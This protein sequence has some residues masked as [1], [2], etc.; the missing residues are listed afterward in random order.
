MTSLLQARAAE[1]QSAISLGSFRALSPVL[2]TLSVLS[3][4]ALAG[5]RIGEGP[6]A[7]VFA[8]Q[9]LLLAAFIALSLVDFRAAVAIAVIELVVGGTGGRWTEFPGDISGR[10]ALD[11]IVTARAAALLVERRRAAFL[12]RRSYS[13]HAVALAFVIPLV[14]MTLGLVN[15]WP[16]GDVFADGNG[17]I[18]FAFILVIAAL[19]QRGD[20][21][22]FRQWVFVACALNAALIGGL[23]LASASGWIS[24]RPTLDETLIGDLDM[25]GVVGYMPNGAYRLYL[26]S[27]L[28]L[29]MGLALTAWRLLLRPRNVVLW[30]LYSVLWIDVAATYTRGFWIGGALAVSLVLGLGSRG[31]RRPTAVLALTFTLFIA[32]TGVAHLAGFSVPDYVFG[33][34]GSIVLSGNE[35]N[36]SS[37]LEE[38]LAGAESNSIRRVQARVLWGHIEEQPM[39]GHGFGAIARDY[40]YAQT[41]AY[42]LSYLHLLFKTGILGTLLFL[43]FHLRIIGDAIRARIGRLRLPE[44]V[45]P[46]EAS[47]VIA[48]IASLLLTGASNPYVLAAFGILPVLAGVAWLEAE[49]PSSSRSGPQSVGEARCG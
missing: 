11:T 27:G 9:V 42:E 6:G 24:L 12:D 25:G 8:A 43:S 21:S 45:P 23:I 1:V 13:L 34:A 2:A 36:R 14:W 28:Y 33:R 38:D 18:F 49:R 17:A 31:W 48:I 7:L 29:Q 47:V 20:G 16:P 3:I 5:L 37:G 39:I 10:I 30:L 22:W 26:G 41:Y 40:P 35:G 19:L 32:A 46:S 4:C 15:G 44:G